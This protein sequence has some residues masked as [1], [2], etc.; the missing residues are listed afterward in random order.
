MV[1]AAVPLSLGAYAAS[2]PDKDGN[3]A[4]FT[5]FIDGYS[6]YKEK[7]Q[8]RNTLHTAAIEQAAFNRNLFHSQKGTTHVDLRFPE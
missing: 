4:G 6:H 8:A 1:L 2:R 5:K 3:V 7:W